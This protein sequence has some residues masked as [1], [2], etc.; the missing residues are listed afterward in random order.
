MPVAGEQRVADP[1]QVAAAELK[2]Y[3]EN[4]QPKW[5]EDRGELTLYNFPVAKADL[6]PAHVKAIEDFGAPAL[7]AASPEHPR[8]DFAVRG[9]ASTTGTEQS[10]ETLALQRA[11][12]V[13]AVLTRM[14]LRGVR[15]SSASSL[16]PVLE[17]TDPQVLARNRRVTVLREM[18]TYPEAPEAPPPKSPDRPSG[19]APDTRLK[20]NLALPVLHAPKV[21]IAPYLIGD[22]RVFIK[23]TKTDPVAAGVL[24]SGGQPELT[25]EFG[26]VLAEQV[27]G[28]RLGVSGGE[29]NEPLK[30]NVAIAA[31][32]W[33]RS[34]KVF[35]KH[36]RYFVYFN[37][38]AVNAKLLPVVD[39]N[40]VEVYLE[41]SGNIK[42]ELGPTDKALETYPSTSDPGPNVTG[43]VGEFVPVKTEKALAIAETIT[44][45]GKHASAL[46]QDDIKN[47]V[48]SFAKR[49]GAA[50]RVAW[51][52]LGEV[53][54][55]LE[56]ERA[57][58][59]WGRHAG[60]DARKAWVEG[61]DQVEGFLIDL[62]KEEKGAR[63]KRMK[64]WKGKYT[65]GSKTFE[66]V[67][68][69]AFQTLKGYDEDQ[70]DLQQLIE[71]M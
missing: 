52:V 39:F 1:Q 60:L 51:E 49:D 64:S 13:G 14:G 24:T 44:E 46:A 33:F 6:A 7:L 5:I 68:E 45:A 71:N 63:E 21:D 47:M 65:A 17:G 29:A 32:E 16:E 67:R 54:G 50:S 69:S 61:S 30:I 31:E 18:E 43:T 28:P 59:E 11:E 36:D 12:N 9:H 53:D 20:I 48:L 15:I 42:F 27:V 10:N 23:G 62:E 35:Y 4:P 8:S 26:K 37:F 38:T 58:Y 57:R 55:R 34:P 22:L 19:L 3:R 56:W 2:W 40:G 25:E 41:F 66:W 70:G